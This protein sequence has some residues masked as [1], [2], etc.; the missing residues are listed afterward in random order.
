MNSDRA[1]ELMSQLL[2]NAMLIAGPVLVTAL[3]VGL[4]VSV[5]QVATQ[6]QEATLSYVP[7]LL[8]CAAVLVLLGPWLIGRLTAYATALLMMIP[9]L[10]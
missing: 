9:Q 4:L 8:A 5:L 3:A 7:K 10:S 6:L 2:W 1:L